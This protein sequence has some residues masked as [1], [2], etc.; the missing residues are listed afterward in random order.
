MDKVQTQKTIQEVEAEFINSLK[1]PEKKPAAQFFFCPVGLVGAGKTTV[2]KPISE[3]FGL[4][5]L[6]SDE[7]RM[8]LKENGFGYGPGKE[9]GFRIANEYARK[10]F[11]VAFDMDCGNPVTVKLVKGLSDELHAKIVWVHINTPEEYIFQKFRNHPPSWLADNPQIMIDNYNAQKKKRAEENKDVHFDFLYTFDTSRPDIEKQIN[12]CEE[13][14][15]EFLT[16]K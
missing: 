14:M 1:I 7:L 10:G 13:K 8:V 4:L 2:T 3:K 11:S 5:R 12:E 16:G 15:S 9:I 6:S